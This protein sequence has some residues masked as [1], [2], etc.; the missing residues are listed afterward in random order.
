MKKLTLVVAL[1]CLGLA[2][3]TSALAQ[4]A[5]KPAPKPPPP[6]PTLSGLNPPTTQP[7]A[8]ADNTPPAGFVALFNGK[9]L[10]GWKGLLK[11]PL[12]NPYNRAK[13]SPED[14]AKAQA[15]ADD[16]MR[17]H[18][19]PED[20]AIAFDGHGR[21]LCTAKDYGDFEMWLDWKIEPKGDSGIYLR[22]SPQVQIWDPS[23][24]SVGRS[25]LGS[26]ALYN[27]E[28]N[29]QDALV[30]ADKPIGQWNTF[31]IRMVGD[32]VTVYLNG[33]LVTANVTMENYWA[34]QSKLGEQPIFPAG[35][36]ELQNHSSPLW[37]KNIYIKELPRAGSAGGQ[38]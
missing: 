3:T 13:L 8:T 12:D 33:K 34:R 19:K 4:P 9:D 30:V 37:F 23:N 2:F 15:E 11:A 14:R 16:D 38:K 26:G 21:S 5:A 18:W 28:H 1:S 10:T 22:G 17:K 6:K 25:E 31:Y 27:N 32:K 24:K 35:Q 36:I 7:T 20:G 29:P